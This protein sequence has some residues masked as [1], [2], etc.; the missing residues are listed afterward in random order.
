MSLLRPGVIEQH[1]VMI[2]WLPTVS[3]FLFIFLL[4]PS[5]TRTQRLPQAMGLMIS[6]SFFLVNDSLSVVKKRNFN[7]LKRIE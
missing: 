1:K 7:L 3:P 5:C 6:L 2:A 4:F